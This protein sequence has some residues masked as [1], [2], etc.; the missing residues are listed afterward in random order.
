MLLLLE[1]EPSHRKAI[2]RY[3]LQAL[4]GARRPWRDHQSAA[5][6]ARLGRI[7]FLRAVARAPFVYWR[8]RRVDSA[9]L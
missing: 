4:A 6:Q 1:E 9:N 7:D 2:A 3:I 8:A 5:L